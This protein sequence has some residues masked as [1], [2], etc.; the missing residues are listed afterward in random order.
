MNTQ[1]NVMNTQANQQQYQGFSQQQLVQHP[2]S[3]Y[4]DQQLQ[5]PLIEN[6]QMSNKTDEAVN[7]NRKVDYLF[8]VFSF[9]IKTYST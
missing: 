2:K 9:M 5:H 4:Y 8:S 3:G 1:Q 7:S 6:P